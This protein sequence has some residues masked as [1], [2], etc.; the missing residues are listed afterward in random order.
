[1]Q[2]KAAFVLAIIILNYTILFASGAATSSNAERSTP[3]NALSK[4][5]IDIMTDEDTVYKVS[6]PTDIRACLD[7][8]NLLGEGQVFS[9]S[10][11]I[12]NYGNTDIVIKI[13][14]IQI[15]YKTDDEIYEFL[16]EETIASDS[17]TKRLNIK[18]VWK[19]EAEK[20]EEILNIEDGSPDK[21]VLFLK[22]SKYNRNNEYVSLNASSKGLFYFTGTLDTNIDWEDIGI[23]VKFD[24]EI[25]TEESDDDSEEI[26]E[27]A[28]DY[29][30]RSGK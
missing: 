30:G 27:I 10:Y 8:G 13:K 23:S 5:I 15:Y 21:Y 28:S 25:E 2:K 17:N 20:T 26:E 11:M 24:Y 3:S 14:N 1:M 16:K 18:M 4:N 19:N 22:A 6:F 9:D 12:E 7:P 29:T